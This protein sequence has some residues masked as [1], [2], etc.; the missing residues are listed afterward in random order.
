MELQAVSN[1][2]TLQALSGAEGGTSLRSENL[3]QSSAACA[4]GCGCG[5]GTGAGLASTAE[6]V[7]LS[8]E[9][10]ALAA[11]QDLQIAAPRSA[12]FASLLLPKAQQAQ[13]AYQ[14]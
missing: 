9:G 14:V 6:Q 10:L 7:S 4:A 8:S 12:G 13:L 11:G 3:E 1:R 5:C 2:A